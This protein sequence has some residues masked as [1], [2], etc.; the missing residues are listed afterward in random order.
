M[1]LIK[2]KSVDSEKVK[3]KEN[4]DDNPSFHRSV[5]YALAYGQLFGLLPVDGVLASDEKAIKFRWRSVKTIYSMIFI[6]CGTIESLLGTRRLLRLGFKINFAEGLLFFIAAIMRALI[7]FRLARNWNG[8]MARWRECEDVFLRPPYRVPGWS[9][10]RQ[11]TTLFFILAFLSI[12]KSNQTILWNPFA[13]ILLPS[14][15]HVF[16]LAVAISDNHLQLLHC[17]PK[18]PVFWEN[19]LSRYRPHLLYH[20]P[21]TPFELPLYEVSFLK[22]S[23]EF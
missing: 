11:I 19:F 7:L 1:G 10:R 3:P 4:Y 23:F 16:F 5:G 13:D 12:C 8:F 21:Y 6:F 18:S 2:V 17:T 22:N 14:V 9:L 20:F 15:E